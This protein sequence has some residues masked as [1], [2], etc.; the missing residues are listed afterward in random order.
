MIARSSGARSKR[1]EKDLAKN[2]L[3][4]E[5]MVSVYYTTQ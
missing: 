4:K 2:S 1:S 5:K 3:R